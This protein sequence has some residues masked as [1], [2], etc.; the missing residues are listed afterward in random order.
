[1][2]R[3]ERDNSQSSPLPGASSHIPTQPIPPHSRS[4]NDGID[5]SLNMT[6]S[7]IFP[8]IS[9]EVRKEKEGSWGKGDYG[10]T[11]STCPIYH[12]RLSVS[13]AIGHDVEKFPVCWAG[14]LRGLSTNTILGLFN[15]IRLLL[16]GWHQQHV[17]CWIG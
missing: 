15:H 17:I 2:S 4:L 5:G 11:E 3:P 14:R 13:H 1:M 9:M 10:L 16:A 8:F 7:M 12:E 6:S